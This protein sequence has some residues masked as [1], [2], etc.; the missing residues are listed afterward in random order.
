MLKSS[1][2]LF[3]FN[4]NLQ[5]FDFFMGEPRNPHFYDFGFFGRPWLPKPIICISGHTRIPTQNHDKSWG[6]FKTH[7]S[8]NL[9]L[10]EIQKMK[11]VTKTIIST[12]KIIKGLKK[13][14]KLT[15]RIKPNI[16][17]RLIVLKIKKVNGFGFQIEARSLNVIVVTPRY[18]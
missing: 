7:R 8:I 5:R 1:A 9:K 14:Q 15:K 17:K 18:G 13:H 6:H 11:P 4:L 10:V 12:R 2:I 16:M 3:R